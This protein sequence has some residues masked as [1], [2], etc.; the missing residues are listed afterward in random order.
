MRETSLDEFVGGDGAASGRG[1][2]SEPN[3]GDGGAS[4]QPAPD[5]GDAPDA[6]IREAAATAEATGT[7]TGPEEADADPDDVDAPPDQ[8]VSTFAWSADGAG[9]ARCGAVV[10]RRWRDDRKLVCPSCKTW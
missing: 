6:D 5:A 8:P 7:D 1:E 4:E 2:P 9:C 10:T 3:R